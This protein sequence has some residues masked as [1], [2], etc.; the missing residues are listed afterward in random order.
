ML[1]SSMQVQR[2]G[3]RRRGIVNLP[4]GSGN[5]YN[6]TVLQ[7]LA[8]SVRPDFARVLTQ[9]LGDGKLLIVTAAAEELAQQFQN[10][11]RPITICRTGREIAAALPANGHTPSADIAVWIY[12][13]IEADDEAVVSELSRVAGDIVLLPGAGAE[14]PKRRPELVEAFRAFGFVPDYNSDVTDLEAGALR[15]VRRHGAEE[16]ASVAEVETAFA[17]LNQKM[18]GVERILRTR[19][20]ELEAA[21]RHIAKLEEKVLSLKEAKRELKQLKAEKHALRKCPERKIGQVILAPY[22]LPQKLFREVAKR[23]EPKHVEAPRQAVNSAS[24]YQAWFSRHQA[25]AEQLTAM[26]AESATFK[27][28]PLISLITPVFNTP[29]A[30]LEAAIDSVLAQA[31]EKWELILIDDASTDEATVAALPALVARDARIY[32]ERLPQS[33]GISAAS[34]RG[35]SVATGDWIGLLDHDDLLEPDALYQTAKLLQEHPDADLIHSDEDKLTE[36][37]FDAPLFKPDWS[38]DFFLSYNYIC[39]FTTLRRTVV[40]AVGGFRSEYDGAQDY[41]L[42]LRIVERTQRIYHVPRILYHWR[43]SAS[44]TSDNIRRK[45]KALE[46]GKRAIEE[47]LDRRGEAGHVAVDWRTHAYWVKREID[48]PHKVCI[49]IPA[50]DAIPLLSRCIDSLVKKTSYSDYEIV[51]VD[52]DSQSEEARDYF[53]RTPHR[54]LHFEGPFNFSAINNFAVEQ[55]QCPWLLFLNNDVEI[56][57]SEWLSAMVEHVQRPEVGAVGARLLYPNGTIQHAGVVLGVGGIA[58]HA[59]RGFPSE[60]PGVNRQLQVTRNYSSVTGACLMTRRE[61]FDEVGGFD[62]ERLPVTFND[63]DLCLRMHRAGY[64]IVYTPFAKLYHH[65]SATRRRSVEALETDVM[66][67]RWAHFLERDPYYNPN[68]SRERADF[69]LG[70]LPIAT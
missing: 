13:Q 25:T 41:D 45:P 10:L 34:N 43:R 14:A 15:L 58:Q 53:A 48:R 68:L 29:V 24:E 26:R 59:F 38:P 50:R 4:A 46:A 30:W 55:T 70:K 9:K 3:R 65:E 40:D 19:M 18:R 62:E 63:V 61:V 28:A 8:H 49:V 17:R 7:T 2:G 36:N 32:F 39:H 27:N 6:V 20:S 69:S 42:F 51:I 35:L 12:A 16:R 67:E 60:D 21:D 56:I 5:Q 66:R 47:H 37:G 1:K 44:S 22:R 23:R 33:A 64:L 54:L 31:Y 11:Q 57:D 52:N